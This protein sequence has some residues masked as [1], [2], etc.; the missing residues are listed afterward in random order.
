[1]E[2]P[3]ENACYCDV[4]WEQS[5]LLNFHVFTNLSILNM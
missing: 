5:A 4:R 1:M 2:Q 3:R